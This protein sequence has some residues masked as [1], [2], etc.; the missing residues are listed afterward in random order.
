MIPDFVKGGIYQS[1]THG[2]VKYCGTDR[3]CGQTTL[4]F[5][6]LTYG[7]MNYWLPDQIPFHFN[8]KLSN[9]KT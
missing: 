2:T 3:Y 9:N 7:G 6:S 5:K 1:R 8:D 4:M